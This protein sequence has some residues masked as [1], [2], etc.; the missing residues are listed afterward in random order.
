MDN[1][2]PIEESVKQ[3]S[4]DDDDFVDPPPASKKRKMEKQLKQQKKLVLEHEDPEEDETVVGPKQVDK[5][6]AKAKK[7]KPAKKLDDDVRTISDFLDKGD[8]QT[9]DEYIQVI[10]AAWKIKPQRK[11]GEQNENEDHFDTRVG[12]QSI[13]DDQ[14]VA[15][16]TAYPTVE[17]EERNADITNM[18]AIEIDRVITVQKETPS[19]SIEE[20]IPL[21]Q[22]VAVQK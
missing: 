6:D 13:F 8:D 9:N 22:E 18:D 2:K 7:D 20:S 19:T 15:H 5:K 21:M 4:E 1:A 3:L 14:N 16:D 12:S 17:K 10:L 11:G